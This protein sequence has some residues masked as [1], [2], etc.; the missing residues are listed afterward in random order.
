MN[1]IMEELTVEKINSMINAI[2]LAITD[3][4]VQIEMANQHLGSTYQYT[5]RQE[6]LRNAKIV[7]EEFK[8]KCT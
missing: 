4:S 2:N 3:L 6:A 7:L 5:W 1:N 8:H